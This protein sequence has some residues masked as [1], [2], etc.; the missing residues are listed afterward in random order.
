MERWQRRLRILDVDRQAELGCRSPRG[1]AGLGGSLEAALV[2]E[3]FATFLLTL[4][5]AQHL[6]PLIVGWG[7]ECLLGIRS[8]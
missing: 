7:R 5:P 8:T 4:S 2:V 6:A 3:S 1:R